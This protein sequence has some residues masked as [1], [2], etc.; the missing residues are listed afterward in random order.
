VKG[1]RQAS[2]RRRKGSCLESEML[3]GLNW[4][5]YVEDGVWWWADVDGI[6]SVCV[7]LEV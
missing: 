2:R 3:E 1:G 4:I 7:S 6:M 5:Q